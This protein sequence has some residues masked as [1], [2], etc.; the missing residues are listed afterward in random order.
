MSNQDLRDGSCFIFDTQA[1]ETV[2]YTL[3]ASET[4]N[5]DIAISVSG[6]QEKSLS[7]RLNDNSIGQV[8]TQKEIGGIKQTLYFENVALEAGNNALQLTLDD[9]D[10]NIYW[11]AVTQ[12]SGGLSVDNSQYWGENGERFDPAARLHEWSFAGYRA[13]NAPVPVVAQVAN[14]A[15]TATPNDGIN[16]A[17]ALQELVDTIPT[18]GAIFIPAGRWNIETRVN[19]SR[20]GVVLRG[21]E[22]T[23]L[24]IP[25]S[26]A[27]IDGETNLSDPADGIYSFGTSFFEVDGDSWSGTNDVPVTSPI[28][29]GSFFVPVSSADG[30]SVGDLVEITQTDPIG[31]NEH[32]LCF[33][34]HGD[35]NELGI[36]SHGSRRGGNGR[37]PTLFRSTAFIEA[38]EGQVIQLD[39]PMPMRIDPIW[40]PMLRTI[41]L[42]R[43][44]SEVGFENLVIRANG[45]PRN[46]H[47]REEGFNGIRF[48]DAINNWVKNVHFIDT[49]NGVKL[50]INTH[51]TTVDGTTYSGDRRSVANDPQGRGLAGHHAI[52]ISNRSN[53]NLVTDFDVQIPYVHDISV[54]GISHHNVFM[55]GK[56]ARLNFDHHRN[57]PWGNLFTEINLG[58]PDRMWASGGRFDRGPY[59]GR[60]TTMWNISRGEGT[61]NFDPIPNLDVT[62]R[63]I[64]EGHNRIDWPYLSV[65]GVTGLSTPSRVRPDQRAEV[66][67][68]DESIEPVN[69][70]EAQLE[71]RRGE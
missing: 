64:S 45:R 29:K 18:P 2:T 40:E 54:E 4:A 1:G 63:R 37:Y 13:Q 69:L 19:I 46:E 7:A 3:N 34:M 27:E 70:F 61:G 49:D 17:V 53:F 15:D 22:G 42:S 10:I 56:G 41:D 47:L 6:D 65:I 48:T 36:D 52:W 20:S 30:F 38:I 16:D 60:D 25:K 23:E 67:G 66:A 62:T 35:L 44:V 21:E 68:N 5:F 9:D 11:L 12:H 57:T 14:L 31:E 8:S 50:D 43:V 33:E 58:E 28:G 32:T 55:K 39:R 24:Y 59:S 26:L 51:Y 71:K